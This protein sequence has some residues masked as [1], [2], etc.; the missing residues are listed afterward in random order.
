[1][2]CTHERFK[3]RCEEVKADSRS[4][5][6]ST[7]RT[8]VNDKRVRQSSFDSSNDCKSLGHKKEALGISEK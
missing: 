4:R 8:E 5:R 2:S 6:P 1:M 3:E 7:S